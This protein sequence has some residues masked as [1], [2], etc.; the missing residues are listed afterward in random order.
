VCSN[1]DV[2]GKCVAAFAGGS[3][4]RCCD[5][6]HD[7]TRSVQHFGLGNTLRLIT[8]NRDLAVNLANPDGEGQGY[9]VGPFAC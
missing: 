5:S 6:E 7:L 9:P 1:L 2:N 8:G 3:P 4:C